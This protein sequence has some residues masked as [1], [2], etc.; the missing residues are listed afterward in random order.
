MSRFLLL[1]ARDHDDPMIAHEQ[2]RFAAALGVDP[3]E[4]SA[5]NLLDRLPTADELISGAVLIGGSGDYSVVHPT[6]WLRAAID[7]SRDVLVDAGRPVFASCFGLQ[8]LT[9]A[10]GGEVISDPERRE[11]GTF[12]IE[13][14]AESD[15]CP[16]FGTL[17]RRF[18]AQEGHND[19]VSR[20]P[21]GVR[22][23]AR[24]VLVQHQAFSLP[25]RP[26]WATQFHPELDFAANRMRY[27]RYIEKYG[28]DMDALEDD[29]V[30]QTLGPS[31]H[32]T[33]L[34]RRFGTTYAV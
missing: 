29:P 8:I 6:P 32:A 11:V 4:L 19:R 7:W 15:A 21:H 31:P 13:R 5:V 1:Q 20:L 23:L 28:G 34:L 33:A 3:G 25:D 27:V 26:I 30:I 18:A 12:E 14:S 9:C 22:H 16:L 17:P 2:Q 24:S 10:L